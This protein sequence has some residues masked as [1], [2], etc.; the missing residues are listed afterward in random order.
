MIMKS[1][2]EARVSILLKYHF[3][4]GCHYGNDFLWIRGNAERLA[5]GQLDFAM[6]RFHWNSKVDYEKL[7]DL[8]FE[9]IDWLPTDWIEVFWDHVPKE[10]AELRARL[11]EKFRAADLPKRMI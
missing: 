4:F 9:V 3:D 7:L 1:F 11:A 5:A 6:R 10:D 2:P 8:A